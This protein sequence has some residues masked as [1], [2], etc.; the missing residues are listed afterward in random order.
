MCMP[1]VKA[2]PAPKPLPERQAPRPPNDSA[3]L[4][5]TVERT[6]RR[7]GYAGLQFTPTAGLASAITTG[8]TL[9]GQ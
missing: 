9:L 4:Q 2:P 5:N 6:R 7:L 8:K 3:I 1:K